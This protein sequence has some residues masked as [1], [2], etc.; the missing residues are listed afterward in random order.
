MKITASAFELK[1]RKALHQIISQWKR[2]N[3]YNRYGYHFI[4]LQHQRSN[5][6]SKSNGVVALVISFITDA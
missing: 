6:P 5:F 1:K 2:E 3:T 4:I